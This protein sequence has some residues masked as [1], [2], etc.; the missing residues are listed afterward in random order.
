MMP[1][2]LSESQYRNL[3]AAVEQND[4]LRGAVTRT[5][6]EPKPSPALYDA[7]VAAILRPQQALTLSVA[8]GLCR[9]DHGLVENG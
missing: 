6:A 2:N 7:K 9:I 1:L 8:D 3:F 5:L 4:L